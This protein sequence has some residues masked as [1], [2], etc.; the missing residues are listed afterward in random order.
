MKL[1][2]LALAAALVAGFP[3]A[4]QEFPGD[5][6]IK[7]VVPFAPGGLTDLLAR[8]TAQFLEQRMKHTIVVENKPGAASAIGIDLVAKS[9]AD[10]H[11]LL[12]VP[13]DFAVLPA[14]R[15][16]LPYKIEDFTYLNRFWLNTALIVAGPNS[17]ITSIQ[18]LLEQL[19]S[20]PGT[21]KNAINGVGSLTHL[22]MLKVQRSVGGEA[23]NIPY[24]GQGPS[25]TDLLAGVIDI[26]NGFSVPFP[27]NLKVLAPAGNF[28]HSAFPTLPTLAELGYK[29][30]DWNVWFGLLAP[31]KMPKAIADRLN[32]ELL[33]VFKDPEAIAKFQL[34]AKHVPDTI[35][36]VGDDFR[37]ATLEELERWKQIAQEEKV[38]VK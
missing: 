4:A 9:P 28:R 1:R 26:S 30:A 29:G 8:T 32:T 2:L 11:T 15:A 34:T 20:K 16:D 10:G 35:P 19:K 22:G 33:A 21:V 37:K 27:D 14:V 36:L 31:P 18:D 24:A 13:S 6:P 5:Q 25:T 23:K 38:A 3:A 12:M 17:P 7:I